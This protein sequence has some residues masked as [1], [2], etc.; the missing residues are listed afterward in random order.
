MLGVVAQTLVST[1]PSVG[2]VLDRIDDLWRGRSSEALVQM[3]VKTRHY[4]RSMRLRIYSEGT[5]RTLIRIM[6]PR[7]ER[8]TATLR[9]G[10]TV[11]MYLPKT[12]RSLRLSAGMMGSAWM[13]SHFSN[14]DLVK[15]SRLRR[16]Y[17][18]RMDAAPDAFTL[19]LTPKPTAAVVWGRIEMT[20]QRPALYPMRA[21]YFDEDQ[22]IARTATFR[23]VGPLGGR[24]LPRA[25]RVVPADAP[26]EYTEIR[27]ET[28]KLDLDIPADTFSVS[29][30]R[31]R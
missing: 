29:A 6:A 13:G 28:L 15:E 4:Q 1:T 21:V 3:E 25:M 8:G 18:V 16:D 23:D 31:R 30:L 11:H 12:D 17:D 27:Y 24:R 20:V 7:K 2:E 22:K 10:E 19:V 14:D 9:V 26:D 5:E